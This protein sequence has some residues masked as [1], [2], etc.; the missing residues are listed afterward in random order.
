MTG[1]VD[2]SLEIRAVVPELAL[3]RAWARLDPRGHARE[4][5]VTVAHR[6]PDGP[7]HRGHE[8]VLARHVLQHAVEV[9]PEDRVQALV[10]GGHRLLEELPLDDE[11]VRRAAER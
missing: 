4:R 1:V 2:E 10:R 8:A 11:G 9:A 3:E 7:P 6:L 5:G